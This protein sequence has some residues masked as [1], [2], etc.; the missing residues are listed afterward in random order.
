MSI[1]SAV[2][3]RTM[4]GASQ[5]M[6]LTPRF[7]KSPKTVQ[8]DSAQLLGLG[9]GHLSDQCSAKTNVGDDDENAKDAL[10]LCFGDC[11]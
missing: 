3:V 2:P 6:L 8:K 5:M 9:Q 4:L 7:G 10:A 1:T 11:L